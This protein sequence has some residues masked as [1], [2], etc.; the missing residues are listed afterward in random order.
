MVIRVYIKNSAGTWHECA[1]QFSES[2]VPVNV[3][4]SA[5][6]SDGTKEVLLVDARMNSTLLTRRDCLAQHQDLDFYAEYYSYQH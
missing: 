3:V 4:S 2:E 5:L 1:C 6:S